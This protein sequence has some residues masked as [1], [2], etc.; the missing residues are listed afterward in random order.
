MDFEQR[1]ERAIGRGAR[2]RQNKGREVADKAVS[3]EE[4][5]NTH[6]KVRLDLSEHID[7]CLQKL[8][9]Y[10]PGFRFQTVVT[11]EGW[12]AKISRDDYKV[13]PGRDAESRYSRLEMLVRPFSS[14]HIVEITAKGT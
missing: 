13:A 14:T 9:D 5:K 10:F 3:E 1:L 7:A 6:S 8:A 2:A 4:L 11:D 12:G